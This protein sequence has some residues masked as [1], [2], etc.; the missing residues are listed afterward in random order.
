ML[1]TVIGIVGGFFASYA[2]SYMFWSHFNK[3]GSDMVEEYVRR[4]KS[5][6]DE[7]ENRRREA[8]AEQSFL[9]ILHDPERRKFSIR[10]HSQDGKKF[11]YGSVAEHRISIPRMS[12]TP[13]SP[14]GA[15]HNEPSS[16]NYLVYVEGVAYLS[17]RP[18][19]PDVELAGN[20]LPCGWYF[21]RGVPVPE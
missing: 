6:G 16:D 18:E 11:E 14:N 19:G 13:I 15:Y 1:P 20:L 7:A 2:A 3:K 8:E 17:V 10:L 4:L 5:A 21:C 9:Q 12:N